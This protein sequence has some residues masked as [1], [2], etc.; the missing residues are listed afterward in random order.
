MPFNVQNTLDLLKDHKIKPEDQDT[1]APIPEIGE[2]GENNEII[3]IN[4]DDVI[5]EDEKEILL[6]EVVLGKL[7]RIIENDAQN[8]IPS[9]EISKKSLRI[10][11]P[12]AWYQ[13]IHYFGSNWGIFIKEEC[14][15]DN[16]L[17][18]APYINWGRARLHLNL[19]ECSRAL[20][21]CSFYELYFHEQYHH[22]VESFG[23]RLLVTNGRD[24]YRNYKSK[25][26]RPNHGKHKCLEEALANAEIFQ[27]LK[28][29]RYKN[30]LR[31]EIQQGFLDYLH[32][33]ILAQ[34]PGYSAGLDYRTKP[35]FSEGQRI[36]QSQIF[37]AALSPTKSIKH[38][39]TGNFLMRSLADIDKNIYVVLPRGSSSV[40][41]SSAID[42][43][44]TVSTADME[45][46][47]KRKYKFSKVPK[48]GKGSHVKLKHPNGKTVI[49]S[50]N[51]R[52]LPVKDIKDAIQAVAGTRSLSSLADL[53]SGDL[54]M[55]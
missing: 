19:Y 47:L 37:D 14:L 8:P 52:T 54:E 43:R 7:K 9:S 32:D 5:G 48:A 15:L 23:L 31:P 2:V 28:E 26:Y 53:I 24:N 36:L 45:K 41:Q 17:R 38:W 3:P 16:M 34:P 18:I 49:L 39:E 35:L 29:D 4:L 25:V 44:G 42:P 27:R 40:I 51:R 50:G 12:C 33:S 10:E 22:K 13:P 1:I 11:S 30:K 46:A 6:P 55:I 20:L 21:R